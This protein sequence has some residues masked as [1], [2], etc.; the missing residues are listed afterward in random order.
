MELQGPDTVM[1]ELLNP[2]CGKNAAWALYYSVCVG[3]KLL[4]TGLVTR[5]QHRFTYLDIMY[6]QHLKSIVLTNPIQW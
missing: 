2:K 6:I 1:K 4:K 5:E 3:E